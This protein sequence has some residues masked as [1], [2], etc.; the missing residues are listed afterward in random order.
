MSNESP[1][2]EAIDLGPEVAQYNDLPNIDTFSIG[3]KH[4]MGKDKKG[5]AVKKQ[6]LLA[7]INGDV[8]EFMRADY[9]VEVTA[10]VGALC[11]TDPERGAKV[12][13][14]IRKKY[15]MLPSSGTSAPTPS[16]VEDEDEA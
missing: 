2:K 9:W 6:S 13:R 15:F 5:N 16:K 11:L 1:G 4:Y 7:R 8:T 12:L 3:I 10:K 14:L